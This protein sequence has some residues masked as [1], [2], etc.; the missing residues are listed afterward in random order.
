MDENNPTKHQQNIILFKPITKTSLNIFPI[1]KLIYKNLFK[2]IEN[3]K[4]FLFSISNYNYFS[5]IFLKRIKKF[6]NKNVDIILMPYEAQPFQN[7]LIK[8]ISEKYKKI[9][10][11]GYV[12]TPPMALPANFFIEIIHQK[13]LY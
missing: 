3:P 1:L 8:F 5:I 13:K 9:K 6:L 11:I 4:Y 7:Q 12:H 2:L 10:T